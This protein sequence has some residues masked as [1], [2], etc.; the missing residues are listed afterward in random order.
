MA[1]ASITSGGAQAYTEGNIPKDTVI[2]YSV[3]G[4]NTTNGDWAI[5]ALDSNIA[6]GL[7]VPWQALSTAHDEMKLVRYSSR[8][9]SGDHALVDCH[10]VNTEI[11]IVRGGTGIEQIQTD[12]YPITVPGVQTEGD[13]ITVTWTGRDDPPGPEIIVPPREQ[14]QPGVITATDIQSSIVVT[15]IEKDYALDSV[16]G[17]KPWVV[18]ENYANFTNSTTW[19]LADPGQWLCED[20]QYD[21]NGMDGIAWLMTYSFRKRPK[22][23]DK[24]AV[25]VWRETGEPAPDLLPGVGR[26]TVRINGRKDF[27]AGFGFRFAH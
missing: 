27:V 5:Q 15:R 18:A 13:D 1:T 25:Y 4:L 6:T 9:L 23:W 17:I 19:L 8:G 22:G 24:E 11:E 3:E 16:T 14:V 7:P 21:P 12:Q 2:T 26:K 10:F 20:I